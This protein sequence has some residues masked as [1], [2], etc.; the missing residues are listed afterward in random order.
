MLA[1]QKQLNSRPRNCGIVLVVYLNALAYVTVPDWEQP[2]L[3]QFLPLIT[4][5][6]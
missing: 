3:G 1:I 6:I 2:Y 5:Y 4:E